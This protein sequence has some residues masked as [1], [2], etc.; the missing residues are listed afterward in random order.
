[1]DGGRKKILGGSFTRKA[2]CGWKKAI[3]KRLELETGD[4]C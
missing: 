1:M 4:G 3:N 2:F